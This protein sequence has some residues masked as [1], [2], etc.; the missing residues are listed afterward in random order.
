MVFLWRNINIPRLNAYLLKD[1]SDEELESFKKRFEFGTFATFSTLLELVIK[2]AP[3]DYMNKPHSYIRTKE[4]E[5]GRTEPFVLIDEQVILK[6][7][8]W[9]V[10]QFADE[11]DVENGEAESTSVLWQVQIKTDAL[12][13]TYANFDNGDI[14]IQDNLGYWGV[15]FPVKEDF[16]QPE[17]SANGGLDT[18]DLRKSEEAWVTAEPGEFEESTDKNLRK[19]F[20]PM[21]DRVGRLKD[22]VAKQIGVKTQWSTCQKAEPKKLPDGTTKEFPEGSVVLELTYDLDFPWPPYEWPEGSL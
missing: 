14:S 10:D 20:K 13:L 22:D 16:E 9:Y 15:E 7:A 8:V 12:P 19:M 5:A 3:E 2:K 18:G 6:D 21:P 11:D 17:V 4:T 1:L